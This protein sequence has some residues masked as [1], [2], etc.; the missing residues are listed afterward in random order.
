[1][2]WDWSIPISLEFTLGLI[3][4]LIPTA[5]VIGLCLWRMYSINLMQVDISVLVNFIYISYLLLIEDITFLLHLWRRHST[6]NQLW[7]DINAFLLCRIKIVDDDVDFK[8]LAASD[9]EK[10]IEEYFQENKPTV[11][12]FIDER[13]QELQQLE[14][15]RQNK[16]WKLIN[17]N[18]G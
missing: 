14:K 3:P 6:E 7:R 4:I 10:D 1:L 2:D 12:E 13:P 9:S 8:A 15:Y 5:F 17:K 18:K 11:A 16:K